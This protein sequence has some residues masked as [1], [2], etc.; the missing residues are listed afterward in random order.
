MKATEDTVVANWYLN[1]MRGKVDTPRDKLK[2]HASDLE[3]CPVKTW[4]RRILPEGQCPLSDKLILFF[5]SG[6]AWEA[7]L[8]TEHQYAIKDGI[9]CGADDKTEHGLT[10]MKS[11]RKWTST[12]N[13]TKSYPHWVFRMKTYA[14]AFEQTHINL[15]V[16]FWVGNGRDVG[17][18]LKAW[19]VEFEANELDE[20]WAE[21]LRRKAILLTA[22]ETGEPIDVRL[23]WTEAWECK[24]CNFGELC[25]AK[26]IVQTK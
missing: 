3:L 15:V 5:A 9:H 18:D 13:P 20:H 14:A 25:Y 23:I 26:E 1:K 24:S 2:I 21:V 6:I 7:W 8:D 11:T 19:R 22:L 16:F 4:Y 10:E 12:F 17:I